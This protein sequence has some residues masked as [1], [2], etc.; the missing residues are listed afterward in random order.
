MSHEA[1]AAATLTSSFN[2]Q[3]QLQIGDWDR[4]GEAIANVTLASREF[5]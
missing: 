1:I 5:R 2:R 4:R 3:A